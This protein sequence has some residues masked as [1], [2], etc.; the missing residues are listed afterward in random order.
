MR[1]ILLLPSLLL[2]CTAF[3][4]PGTFIK[5]I[6]KAIAAEQFDQADQL[7]QKQL[8][9]KQQ[10]SDRET[11]ALWHFRGVLNSHRYTKAVQN[12][13][14][15]APFAKVYLNNAV[16]ALEK[17]CLSPYTTYKQQSLEAMNDLFELLRH[18]SVRAYQEEQMEHFYHFARQA[19]HC[20]LFVFKH[21]PTPYEWNPPTLLF[22]AHGA[23][24]TGRNEEAIHWY[25][26][27]IDLGADQVH[28]ISNACRLYVRQG[29]IANA[30][31]LL[32]YGLVKHPNAQELIQLK[33][34]LNT[35]LQLKKPLNA[36]CQRS[37]PQHSPG[38]A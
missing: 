33:T 16:M 4:S 1:K 18:L 37:V 26:R 15:E 17:S 31:N 23:E 14:L 12:W 22:A 32:D 3:L 20:N 27:M 13:P 29:D 30:I 24:L 11:A 21:S 28:I 2:L 38:Q 8:L 5:E 10:L 6:E 35:R 25:L 19:S 9:R 36:S 34:D 7:I